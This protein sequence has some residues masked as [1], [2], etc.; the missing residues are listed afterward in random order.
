VEILV[1]D[2]ET[3]G[4]LYNEGTIVEMGIVGLDLESGEREL[5]LD[6]V[7]RE[8][9]LTEQHLTDEE[10]TWIFQNS[11]LTP[12]MV[13]D[14]P[15]AGTTYRMAR[16]I[17]SDP[18]YRGVTAYN[19][20]FDLMYLRDRGFV[21]VGLPCP[22]LLATEVVR[23]PFPNG[24][25]CKWP[26]VEQAYNFFFPDSEYVETHRAADDA[27]HEAQIVYELFKRGKYPL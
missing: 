8:K 23:I 19:K 3:A 10:Y 27:M 17:F 21:I 4:F 15:P 20:K 13:R 1:V 22:M 7:V 25:C 14:A 16:D 24:K 5:L 18:R 6:A 11:T 26:T 12:E 2:I 9:Q